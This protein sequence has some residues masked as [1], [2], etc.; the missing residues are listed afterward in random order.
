MS[1]KN[2]KL[3]NN[4]YT[5]EQLNEI[6]NTMQVLDMYVEEIDTN[7]NLI[8]YIGNNVKAFMPREE[9]SS[10]VNDEGLVDEKYIVN[11]KS[12][13]FPVCIK[14]VI[15]NSDGSL[16]IIASKKI[17][18]LKVR[19][20]MYMHLKPGVKLKGVVVNLLDYG[21]FAD[22]GG[23]VTGLIKL[24]DISN[25]PIK[26]PSE[27]L[28]IGQRINVVVKKY[29]RDTGKIELSYKEQLGTFEQNVKKIK[30]G[31]IVEGVVKNR[32]KTG[33]FVELKPGL[34]GL[35]EHVS[36]IEYGQKVLVSIKKISLE[37]KK[38]KLI[39]IG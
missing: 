13:K 35:A 1:E 26:H 38:I 5:F 15:Q 39:I 7:F 6:K 30:E 17:L 10:V 33:V 3:K 34:V 28:K 21:A 8:G 31:D 12:K 36:G 2:N 24:S 23:G 14:D 9:F 32:I 18:E 16:E 25:S 4:I 20:W 22:V 19:K 27:I 11:K 37:K 29:D